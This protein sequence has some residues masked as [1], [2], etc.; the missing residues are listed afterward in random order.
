MKDYV[1]IACEAHDHL[2][3]WSVL[4]ITCSIQYLDSNDTVA[5]VDSQ[6][7]DV[8]AKNGEEF[9]KIENGDLI[10]LDRIISINGKSFQTTSDC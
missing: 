1:P 8:F 7:I 5:S 6:I 3:S 2:E 4:K 9:I 10:R